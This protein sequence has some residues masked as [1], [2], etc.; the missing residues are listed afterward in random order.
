MNAWTTNRSVSPVYQP[1]PMGFQCWVDHDTLGTESKFDIHK[2]LRSLT[3]ND[4]GCRDGQRIAT[5]NWSRR[6]CSSCRSTRPSCLA[7]WPACPWCRWQHRWER[8]LRSWSF[9]RQSCKERCPWS[10]C[11]TET[12]LYIKSENQHQKRI[13]KGFKI[14][15]AFEPLELASKWIIR[16]SLPFMR[17]HQY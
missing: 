11:N 4:F 9:W 15:W 17:H 10:R 6:V 14:C 5:Q 3:S 7:G 8:C 16:V 12:E 13:I 1:R 2:C